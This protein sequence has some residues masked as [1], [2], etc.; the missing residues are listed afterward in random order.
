MFD[1]NLSNTI[2]HGINVMLD[3]CFIFDP[4]SNQT[5]WAF[6][7]GINVKNIKKSNI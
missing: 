4:V 6:Q 1:L 2:L 3:R 7:N 5:K